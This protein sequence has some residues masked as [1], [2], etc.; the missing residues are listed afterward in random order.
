MRKGEAWVESQYE[1]AQVIAQRD[2]LARKQAEREK[3]KVLH[4]QAYDLAF[5]T[6]QSGLSDAEKTQH[7]DAMTKPPRDIRPQSVRLSCYFRE[8][9]WPTVQQDYLIA[10]SDS[11]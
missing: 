7:I 1:P 4:D 5:E 9:V 2:L 8:R 10:P 11:E 3:L 6:W